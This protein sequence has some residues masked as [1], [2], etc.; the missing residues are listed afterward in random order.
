MVGF[1]DPSYPGSGTLQIRGTYEYLNDFLFSSLFFHSLSVQ[2]LLVSF[3]QV[4]NSIFT[5]ISFPKISNI[6][7]NLFKQKR[8]NIFGFFHMNLLL[9]NEEHNSI[10]W[11][12]CSASLIFSLV[13][14]LSYLYSSA[15]TQ[16]LISN[17]V[18]AYVFF[19]ICLLNAF[20]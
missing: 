16:S 7:S 10:G 2:H 5:V 4:M 12:I 14:S 9:N 20:V 15:Q 11:R 19:V 17:R 8:K 6:I 18:L 3:R 13:F 1:V